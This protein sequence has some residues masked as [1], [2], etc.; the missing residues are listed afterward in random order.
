MKLLRPLRERDFALLWTG[1][2]VSLLGDGI[3]LV[4]LAWQVYDLSNDPVALSLVGTAWTL[5]MVAFLLTGGLISDRVERRKVLVVADVIR[6]A[7][8]AAMGVLSLTGAV[9]V[10]HLV[11][12]S[13]FIGIGEAFFGPAFGALVPDVVATEHLVQANA[14]DQ[15]VRQ[16]AARLAGPALGGLVVAVVGVGGAFL[17]DAGTFL[18]SAACVAALRVRSIPQARARSARRELREGLDFVR[19]QP[20][21]WSTL[22]AASIGLLFF[23][24]PLEVL[25]PFIVRNELHAGPGG[26]G[27]I[28]AAAGVGAVL[29]SLALSHTGVPRRY[30]TFSYVGWTIGTLPFLGFALCD[31]LWQF[32][33]LSFVYGLC[34]SAGM[35]VWG[36]LMSTRVPAEL[37]GRV[38][39]LDWF[40]SI[41]LTPISFALTGPV[42][43]AIGIDATLALAGIVPAVAC[44]VLYV[45]AGLRRDEER[46]AG[47]VSGSSTTGGSTPAIP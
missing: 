19:G 20:W 14:L 4:A 25:L 21:L 29:I 33:L 13:V 15:L 34:E 38:H 9:E 23:L 43:K 17:L 32:A 5:G 22:I 28:L 12:L 26:Y 35:V 27:A 44:V 3:F 45:V 36:T 37:R 16:A 10:W 18:L 31:Q 11:S 24:G 40:V 8:L 42:S 30:L 46:H 7:A 2:T 6:A 41:A 39:S 1:M 47:A